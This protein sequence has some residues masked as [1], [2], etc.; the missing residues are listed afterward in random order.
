MSG[1]QM[2]KMY[3]GWERK[4]GY[5]IEKFVMSE[6]KGLGLRVGV[7]ERYN[8]KVDGCKKMGGNR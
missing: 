4:I 3:R 8:S 2:V 5:W 1:S 6:G 7:E